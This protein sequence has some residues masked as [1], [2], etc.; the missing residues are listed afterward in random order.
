MALFCIEGP[1]TPLQT[2][3]HFDFQA[4]LRC[5]VGQSLL[6]IL[7]IQA[8]R[9]KFEAVAMAE[10]GA[11]VVAADE[12]PAYSVSHIKFAGSSLLMKSGPHA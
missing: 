7:Y 5:T 10:P 12:V 1:N 2:W 8:S 9:D 6:Y 4:Y 3:P 11:P